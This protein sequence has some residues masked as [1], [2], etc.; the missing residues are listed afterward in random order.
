MQSSISNEIKDRGS[1]FCTCSTAKYRL[2]DEHLNV[3][4]TIYMHIYAN[5]FC[6]FVS[7][8]R[9]FVGPYF[10][11]KCEKVK[12]VSSIAFSFL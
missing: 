3:F 2:E 9:S 6:K 11:L 1:R 8:S 12:E 7:K 4:I 5:Y 10:H